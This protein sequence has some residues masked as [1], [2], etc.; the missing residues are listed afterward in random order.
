M[1]QLCAVLPLKM[2]GE[3]IEPPWMPS[4]KKLGAEMN[5]EEE[6]G[7]LVAQVL[8][9][10]P[11]QVEFTPGSAHGHGAE[12]HRT[13]A[14]K[15]TPPP[16]PL[17]GEAKAQGAEFSE[18][19]GSS[20]ASI[21]CLSLEETPEKIPHLKEEEASSACQ[22]DA[23]MNKPLPKRKSALKVYTAVHCNERVMFLNL[24]Q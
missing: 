8:P 5:I 19:T 10:Q 16:A 17:Q 12:E 1:L 15:M 9:P 20:A 22:E 21:S 6:L 11:H 24:G 14:P 4:L 18:E 3:W 2:Q 23:G 13:S 7:C